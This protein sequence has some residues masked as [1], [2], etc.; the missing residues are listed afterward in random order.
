MFD[1][2]ESQKKWPQ[3]AFWEPNSSLKFSPVKSPDLGSTAR[4]HWHCFPSGEGAFCG[5][6]V[7]GWELKD[8]DFFQ[9]IACGIDG[10]YRNEPTGLGWSKLLLPTST[11]GAQNKPYSR[12]SSTEH[13]QT[14]PQLTAVP[15]T[16]PFTSQFADSKRGR[17]S[18]HIPSACPSPRQMLY[19]Y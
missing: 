18:R 3:S 4:L 8:I 9:L 15:Y 16:A 5:C 11:T 12:G 2:S 6:D 1:T 17:E 14:L 19:Y 7:V 13:P 10:N